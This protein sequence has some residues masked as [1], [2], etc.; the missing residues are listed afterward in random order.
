MYDMFIS[1]L[2]DSFISPYV[3]ILLVDVGDWPILLDQ[4][5]HRHN[6]INV[7]ILALF[8]ILHSI[9]TFTFLI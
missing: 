8:L 2:V 3:Y 6:S 1:L 9:R 7:I 5:S 4:I